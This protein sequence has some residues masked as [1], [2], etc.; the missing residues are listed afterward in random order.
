MFSTCD[1][2]GNGALCIKRLRFMY[3][4]IITLVIILRSKMYL[5]RFWKKIWYINIYNESKNFLL[6]VQSINKIKI[7]ISKNSKSGGK[8]TYFFRQMVMWS[9][10]PQGN[11]KIHNLYIQNVW[12]WR[13]QIRAKSLWGEKKRLVRNLNCIQIFHS[14]VC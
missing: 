4:N 1:L 3:L 11:V 8:C 6:K 7:S 10:Y 2:N 5:M 12:C 13:Q 14:K 9:S